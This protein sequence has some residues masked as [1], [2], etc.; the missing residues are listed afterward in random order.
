MKKVLLNVTDESPVLPTKSNIAI[1]MKKLKI[2][3]N[4]N[5]TTPF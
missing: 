5:T 4:H 3:I 1:N 2:M